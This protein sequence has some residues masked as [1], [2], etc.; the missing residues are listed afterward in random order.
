METAT[1]Y[2]FKKKATEAISGT[3]KRY[4]EDLEAMSEEALTTCPGGCA[5]TPADFTYEI[6]TLN[7]R[8]AKR[9]RGED[10]GPSKFDGW[11]KAPAEFNNKAT[12]IAEFTDSSKEI[13]DALAKIPEDEMLRTIQLPKDTTNP[14]DLVLFASYHTGYHCAQLNYIQTL[15]ND[16]EI[17]WKFDD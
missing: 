11:I 6:V 4:L 8:I 2:E 5:R 12:I 13:E 17:H 3:R 14:Y 1:Q 7:R 16:A 10:P 15:G 9:L